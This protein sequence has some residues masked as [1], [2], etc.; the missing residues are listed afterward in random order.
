MNGIPH[1]EILSAIDEHDVDLLVFGTHER[2]GL[3]RLV[4][5]SVAER[6]IRTAEIPVLTVRT[7]GEGGA[8]D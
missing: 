3:D 4:L 8:P 5:G 6:L 1:R 2:S 7:A